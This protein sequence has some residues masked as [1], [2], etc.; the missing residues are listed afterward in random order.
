MGSGTFEPG[1]D[2]FWVSQPAITRD[3]HVS[4]MFVDPVTYGVSQR[5]EGKG[6]RGAANVEVRDKTPC[7]RTD[8]LGRGRRAYV[9]PNFTQAI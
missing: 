7:A 6:C 3:S 4:V 1:S 8:Y 9:V 5:R 2:T